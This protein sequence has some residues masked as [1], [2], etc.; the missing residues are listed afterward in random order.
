MSYPASWP[1]WLRKFITDFIEN[2]LTLILAVQ[3]AMP[4]NVD[5]GIRILAIFG[6]AIAGGFISA[7]RRAV[8]GFVIWLRKKMGTTPD[9]S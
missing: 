4:A 2:S 6:A 8:P 9:A 3:F 1:E 5:E 7:F